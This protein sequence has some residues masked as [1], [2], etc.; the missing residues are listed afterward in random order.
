MK[1][2]FEEFADPKAQQRKLVEEFEAF[3]KGQP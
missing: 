1:R 2:E 3:A